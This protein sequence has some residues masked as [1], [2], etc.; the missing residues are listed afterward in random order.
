MPATMTAIA[1][2]RDTLVEPVYLKRDIRW[3]GPVNQ[4]R[5]QRN[6]K[7]KFK[8]LPRQDR[9]TPILV[10]LPMFGPLRRRSKQAFHATRANRAGKDMGPRRRR[11]KGDSVLAIIGIWK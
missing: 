9:K 7:W 1:A 2:I 4:A 3:D 8:T 6:G 11:E 10:P 5:A